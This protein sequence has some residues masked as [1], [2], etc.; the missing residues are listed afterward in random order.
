MIRIALQKNWLRGFNVGGGGRG[1]QEICHLLYAD[2][3][4]S[5]CEPKVEQV[6]YIRVLLVVFEVISGF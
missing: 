4:V 2:D 5:S 6:C 1:D 3:T